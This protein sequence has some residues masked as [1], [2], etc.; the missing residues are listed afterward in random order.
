M[1]K[2]KSRK[3]LAAVVAGV[4]VVGGGWAAIAS[5]QS[6]SNSPQAFF[7]AVAKHLGISSQE[8]EEATKA[9]AIDQVDA[10]LAEGKITEEQAERLKER[11]ESGETPPFFFGPRFFGEHRGFHLHAPGGQLSAAADYLGLSLEELRERLRDGRS[12]ADVA[13]A[14]E[15]SVEGLEQAM[16]DAVK[17][18]LD[19]AVSEG[20][21][22]REQ[23]DD[24]LE[25][26]EARID[27]IVEGG[28]E[29]W[30]GRFRGP[31]GGPPLLGVGV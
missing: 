11:I 17:K 6:D 13:K 25:Q 12:L 7:D 26:I 2:F 19:E 8:L 18:N 30:R 10:A 22:T 24:I 27:D 20:N 23:A 14:E 1:S 21:L 5:A 31:P 28:V 4:V 9:A 29:K 16:V 15:K 3:A